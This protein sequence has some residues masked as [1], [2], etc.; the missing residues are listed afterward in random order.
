VVFAIA[1]VACV[2]KAGSDAGADAG[3]SAEAL[4]VDAVDAAVSAPVGPGLEAAL[5][6][7]G[8]FVVSV[9]E[10]VEL[11]S[12]LVVRLP[13]RLR[14]GRLRLMDWQDKVV[15]SDDTL[16]SDGLTYEIV[17]LEPLKSGR[18]YTVLLDAEVGGAVT[19]ES[20]ATLDDWALTFTVAGELEP[21]PA[22]AKTASPGKPKRRR[23]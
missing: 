5:P 6:D 13:V 12:R 22:P 2:P 20:G 14:D 4:A 9:S 15:P 11:P 18:S 21:D 10:P 19:D 1:V 16:S 7:G 17:P 3:A 23:R 8:F